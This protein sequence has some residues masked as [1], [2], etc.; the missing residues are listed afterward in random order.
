MSTSTAFCER[1][2]PISGSVSFIPTVV[3]T[4]LG[5]YRFFAR[6]VTCYFIIVS[7][8]ASFIIWPTA[9][10]FIVYSQSGSADYVLTFH[11]G[12]RLG[13]QAF[14]RSTGIALD[15]SGD[16]VMVGNTRSMDFPLK[17]AL[18]VQ[19]ADV[20][21][22][23][24]KFH[25]NGTL[26]WSTYLGG[27]NADVILDVTIDATG[28]I[29]VGGWTYTGNGTTDFP[30]KNGL[31]ENGGGVEDA[32]ITKIT[33]D[34][35]LAFSTLLGGSGRDY[36]TAV[37]VDSR[38]NI[39][40]VGETSSNDFPL[41][42]AI[43]TSQENY[44]AFITMLAPNGSLMFS[45]YLG[46]SEHDV[47]LSVS[48]DAHDA[49]T[50]T[51][52][53][54]SA[55]FPLINAFDQDLN[56]TSRD[57]FITKITANGTIAFSSFLGGTNEDVGSS[58]TMTPNG[59]RIIVA[60]WTRSNDFPLRQALD[61]RLNGLQDS[62]VTMLSANGSL[63]Y[64]TFLGGDG[65]DAAN[66][67]NVDSSGEH[68]FITGST[69]STNFPVHNF[70][71]LQR[72]ASNDNDDVFLIM[73]NA[74]GSTLGSLVLGSNGT[75]VGSGI[76]VNELNG[77]EQVLVVGGTNSTN[78][79]LTSSTSENLLSTWDAFVAEINVTH[80]RNDTKELENSTSQSIF[81]TSTIFPLD[82]IIL[83]ASA[84]LAINVLQKMKRRKNKSRILPRQE[85]SWF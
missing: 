4:I 48:T 53:T 70:N 29:I 71:G 59:D 62:F 81:T 27:S 75:D 85:R 2:E 64:S 45:T 44:D 26:L 5:R 57:A 40:V 32:F 1:N 63:L 11:D 31:R 72:V 9:S 50:V 54:S 22:F 41:R 10:S 13:G 20:E 19:L 33:P 61:A 66:D 3:C 60:G 17:D 73:M 36:A 84:V 23:I 12:W 16:F 7:L 38:D 15:H 76:A 74:N 24:T 47:A 52:Y 56:G 80:S 30:I 34:G 79:L 37:T 21:G 25:Q 55:D 68:V 43:D 77:D 18:D 69:S 58:V 42:D 49:I 14:D 28:N 8:L 39:I 51:G 83:A 67:V 82:I 46:G 35:S 78:F 6:I 65:I